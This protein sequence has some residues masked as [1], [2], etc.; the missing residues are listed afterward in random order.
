[1]VAATIVGLL[2]AVAGPTVHAPSA[3]CPERSLRK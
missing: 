2:A 1:M 3:E